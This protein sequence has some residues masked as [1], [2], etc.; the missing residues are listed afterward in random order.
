MMKYVY[1]K[2]GAISSFCFGV[3]HIGVL[4][5]PRGRRIAGLRAFEAETVSAHTRR[6]S[7]L[8]REFKL[9]L[10]NFGNRYDLLRIL[11]G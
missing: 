10:G 5:S 4:H 3:G 6:H 7:S 8:V 9:R 11:T 2:F 1:P